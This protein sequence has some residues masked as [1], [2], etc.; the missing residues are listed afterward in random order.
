MGLKLYSLLICFPASK[1][2]TF[3]NIIYFEDPFGPISDSTQTS[4]SSSSCCYQI[5]I[6]KE[7]SPLVITCSYC[8]LLLTFYLLLD[9]SVFTWCVATYQS[10]VSLGSY[11]PSNN[12][13]LVHYWKIA[14]PF[15]Q[16]NVKLSNIMIVS[17][18]LNRRFSV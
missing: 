12:H 18:C 4:H 3:Y 10:I 6:Q 7:T 1:C 13:S 14:P 11:V 5:R 16:Y 8:L 9:L 15:I 17:A 2:R